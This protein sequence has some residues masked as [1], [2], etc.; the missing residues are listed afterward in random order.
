MIR[1]LWAK[2][3]VKEA[4][5]SMTRLND[6]AVVVDILNVIGERGNLFTL[7]MCVTLLPVLNDLLFGQYEE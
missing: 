1:S 4:I 5:D 3:D 7:D 6:P 2:G